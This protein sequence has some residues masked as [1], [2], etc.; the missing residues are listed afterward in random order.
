VD[1]AILMTTRYLQNRRAGSDK[2]EAVSKAVASSAQSIL[3][4]GIGFL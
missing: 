4:S 3:V 2:R 1:Y